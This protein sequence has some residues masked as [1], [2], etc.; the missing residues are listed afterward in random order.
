MTQIMT[1]LAFAIAGLA[2]GLA[3]G[4]V[5]VSAVVGRPGNDRRRR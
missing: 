1:N 5:A 4:R 2:V 3:A